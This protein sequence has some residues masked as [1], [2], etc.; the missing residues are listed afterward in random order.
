MQIHA[1]LIFLL[2]LLFVFAPLAEMWVM[3]SDT[4][5]YRPFLLWALVIALVYFAQGGSE[6]DGA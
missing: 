3:D 5:W 1:A 2:S 6:D 4:A